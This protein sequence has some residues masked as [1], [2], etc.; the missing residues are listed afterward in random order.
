[1]AEN[2]V[3]ISLATLKR[4]PFYLE[5]LKQEK[6]K[7]VT[8]SSSAAIARDLKINDVQV[9]KDIAYVTKN[10]GKPKTGHNIDKLISDIESF[11]GMNTISEA[12]LVGVGNLGK[13][14]LSYNGFR[15]FG[16]KIIGAFDVDYDL[17]GKRINDIEIYHLSNLE[18]ICKENNIHIGIITVGVNNAQEICDLLV[19]NGVQAIWNF[20][21]IHLNV[22]DGIIIQNENMASS[23]AVLSRKLKEI[24]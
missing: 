22:P 4:I 2:Q 5:Y 10:S 16:L 24:E 9:R 13:A 17:I 1:M 15:D 8:V 14:L 20:A 21:P 3:Y 11:L 12:V 23:L 18:T 6:A 7:G 19:K